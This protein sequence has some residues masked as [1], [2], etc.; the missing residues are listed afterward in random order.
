MECGTVFWISYAGWF[1][2]YFLI[3][4]FFQFHV[5]LQ[6]HLASRQFLSACQIFAYCIQYE[7]DYSKVLVVWLLHE[8]LL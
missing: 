6:T 5:L 7:E 3:F 8:L 2:F 4:S 1:L